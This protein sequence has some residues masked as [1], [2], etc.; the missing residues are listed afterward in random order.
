M[1]GVGA[2]DHTS[3]VTMTT[4]PADAEESGPR[5]QVLYVVGSG[6]SGTSTLSGV[7]KALGVPVPQPEVPPNNTNPRGFGEPAWVV[8]R[9]QRWLSKA[10]VHI[11]DARPQAWALTADVVQGARTV[12]VCAD[13]L[14]GR[15]EAHG[16]TLLVKDPRLIWFYDLWSRAARRSGAEAAYLIM[17]RPPTEVVASK[18]AYY[19]EHGGASGLVAAWLNVMLRAEHRTRS[20]RRRFIRYEDLL[21][22]WRGPVFSAAQALDLPEVSMASPEA[23]A[24]VDDF[25]DPTLRRVQSTWEDLPVPGSLRTLA[26]RTWE[27]LQELGSEDGNHAGAVAALDVLR[28]EYEAYYAETEAVAE[29]SIRAAHRNGLREALAQAAATEASAEEAA[30]DP[31]IAGRARL[32]TR[33][34]SRLPRRR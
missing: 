6:R 25:L 2:H 30:R 12:E 15:F 24:R 8:K 19:T 21:R 13:W 16:D 32:V 10:A 17:L 9:H 28:V 3:T 4:G 22:D 29:S 18:Q 33:L 23:R 26:Q 20:E 34:A 14:A 5:R 31:Q 27:A 1:S 11:S 7:L